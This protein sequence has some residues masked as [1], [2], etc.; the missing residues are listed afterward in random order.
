MMNAKDA[1]EETNKSILRLYRVK[2]EYLAEMISAAI[3]RGTYSVVVEDNFLTEDIENDLTMQG[4]SLTRDGSK[5]VV[6]W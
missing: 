2:M 3:D 6:E 5:I 1:R 4:Y